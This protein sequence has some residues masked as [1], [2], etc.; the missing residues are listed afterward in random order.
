MS[1]RD[2]SLYIIDIYIAINKIQRYTQE[3]T[4]PEDF[5]WS[6]LQWDA[7]IR[8]LEIIGE[9]T[10]NL[11]KL[12]ILEN[13]KYRKIVDFRNIIVHGYFGIDEN[14]VWSVV[15]DKLTLF[16]LELQNLVT[17]KNIDIQNA[18]SYAKEE[19]F[20][21]REIIEFD[22]CSYKYNFN[23]SLENLKV[24]AFLLFGLEKVSKKDCQIDEGADPKILDFFF[25]AVELVEKVRLALFSPQT[26][27]AVPRNKILKS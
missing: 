26:V 23:I 8:E 15:K 27:L 4:N 24:S 13:D 17:E 10:N 5:K 2:I 25:C 3:F 22:C 11:I 20:K 1:K 12:D 21:N 18:V 14:E 16:F 7:T 9:A 6:E 19:N